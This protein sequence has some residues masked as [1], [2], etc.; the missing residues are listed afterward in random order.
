MLLGRIGNVRT[1]KTLLGTKLLTNLVNIPENKDKGFYGAANWP[2]YDK[3]VKS[4]ITVDD[5]INIHLD[6]LDS[7]L[8]SLQEFWAWLYNRLSGSEIS[9]GINPI[10]LQSG[11][12][13]FDIDWDSQLASSVDLTVRRLTEK[14]WVTRAPT[15]IRVKAYHQETIAYNYVYS[16]PRI[17]FRY[18]FPLVGKDPN[19]KKEI[20]IAKRYYDLFDTRY[21]SDLQYSKPTVPI[22]QPKGLK[23]KVRTLSEKGSPKT[24]TPNEKKALNIEQPVNSEYPQTMISPKFTGGKELPLEPQNL[25]EMIQQGRVIEMTL[26]EPE[27]IEPH[28]PKTVTIPEPTI[29]QTQK[30]LAIIP[31]G[32]IALSS[33]SN[34]ELKQSGVLEPIIDDRLKPFI[35]IRDLEDELSNGLSE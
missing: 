3:R 11:K 30:D 6:E 34:D 19:S 35:K 12:R 28:I 15:K 26:G 14:F 8:V 27:I 17:L 24:F 31:K 22:T 23:D 21:Q 33:Y 32:D 2:V 1:G 4:P 10:V 13:G 20:P 18:K 25:E 7:G 5:F 29:H 16:T 9:R